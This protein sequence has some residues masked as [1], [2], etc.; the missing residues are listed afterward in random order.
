M[1]K[2]FDDQMIDDAVACIQASDIIAERHKPRLIA[3]I[4]EIR[5]PRCAMTSSCS[6]CGSAV[7]CEDRIGAILNGEVE[8]VFGPVTTL[9]LV[10]TDAA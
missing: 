8:E 4:R 10:V 6:V 3:R 1:P 9:R 7:R 2:H 5:Q